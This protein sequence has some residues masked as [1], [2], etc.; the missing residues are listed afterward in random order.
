MSARFLED[1]HTQNFVTAVL[2]TQ[3]GGVN[4]RHAMGYPL[5]HETSD[6]T[7]KVPDWRCYP[8]CEY[9]C[10]L[11]VPYAAVHFPNPLNISTISYKSVF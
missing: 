5:V 10:C 7:I 9:E 3:K 2:M 4:C 6:T 1:V 11:I 8:Y